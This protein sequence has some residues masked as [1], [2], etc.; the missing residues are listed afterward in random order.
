MKKTVLIISILFCIILI[1]VSLTI[2]FNAQRLKSQLEQSKNMI[3]GLEGEAAR[4]KAEREKVTQENE[5]LQA[6]TVSYVALNTK[7]QDEKEKL[8]KSLQDAQKIIETKEGDLERQRLKLEELEKKIGKDKTE[9]QDSLLKTKEALEKKIVSLEGALRRERPLYHYNLAVAYTQAGL[10]EEAIEAYEKALSFNP[11]NPE[12]HYNLGLL[13][14]NFK[15]DPEQ[16]I[17]HYQKYLELK[18]KAEDKEE[19]EASIA[20]LKLN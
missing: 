2:L 1:S 16:A 8:Q 4:I 18:P 7:L 19:V 14:Q 6:D 3:Q 13:Y 15:F 10:Y 12:A 11:Q 9:Q 20:K 17:L 5:R